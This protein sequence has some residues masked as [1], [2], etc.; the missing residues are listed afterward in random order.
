MRRKLIALSSLFVSALW[1]VG[2]ARLTFPTQTDIYPRLVGARALFERGVSPY[3]QS[4][5]AEIQTG[6]Y[7]RPLRPD[8]TRDQQRFVYPLYVSFLL[9]PFLWVPSWAANFFFLALLA[10]AILLNLVLWLG[11][12]D[13]KPRTS[14]SAWI[15]VVLFLS[16]PIIQGLRIQNLVTVVAT[17]LTVAIY[18]V[19]R[20]RLLSAGLALAFATIK[21]QAALLPIIWLILWSLRDWKARRKLAVSFAAAMALLIA[22]SCLL[23]P[24]WIGEWFSAMMSYRKYFGVG[25]HNGGILLALV[26]IAFLVPLMWRHTSCE[27]K[28]HEFRKRSAFLMAMQFVM[29]WML[30][31]P[32]I[33]A[34]YQMILLLPI[35]II[36][37]APASGHH[38]NGG[39]GAAA[40]PCTR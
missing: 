19:T 38:V 1:I 32:G 26:T 25:A 20:G 15:L 17:L 8:E 37:L 28:S 30:T 39:V 14:D 40:T 16:P 11:L 12:A 21:P 10:A 22:T 7:G 35:V 24:T 34:P 29:I 9:L 27:A 13:W 23:V 2:P 33:A 3:S 6:F 5:T 4:V 31:A 36:L 18:S